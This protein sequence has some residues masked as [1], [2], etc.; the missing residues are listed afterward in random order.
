MTI[1]EEAPKPI[2]LSQSGKP[3]RQFGGD[4][5]RTQYTSQGFNVS[6]EWDLDGEPCAV[7]WREHGDRNRG[8]WVLC[9]S[10]Y[11]VMVRADGRPEQL[12]MKMVARGLATMGAEIDPLAVI[13]LFDVALDAYWHVANT[14]PKRVSKDQNMFDA[15]FKVNG[16]TVHE[17]SI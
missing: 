15:T 14:P 12:G 7:F 1:N 4:A 11:P 9:L 13:K 2:I 16:R 6:I 10:A 5:A 3:I 17:K 8:A